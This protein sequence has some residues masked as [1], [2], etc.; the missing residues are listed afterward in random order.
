MFLRAPLLPS[1]GCFLFF[2]QHKNMAREKDA[3]NILSPHSPVVNNYFKNFMNNS[4][5]I[6]TIPVTAAAAGPGAAPD[7]K[8]PAV[9]VNSRICISNSI[10]R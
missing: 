6:F 5:T 1:T 2:G 10:R 7:G 4:L 8:D 3:N 9:S